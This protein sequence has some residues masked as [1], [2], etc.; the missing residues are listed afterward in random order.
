M[1]NL[2]QFSS[3]ALGDGIFNELNKT[4]TSNPCTSLTTFSFPNINY[5]EGGTEVVGIG[6]LILIV[7]HG[8]WQSEAQKEAI[9]RHVAK[10]FRSTANS[11]NCADVTYSQAGGGGERWRSFVSRGEDIFPIGSY[12]CIFHYQPVTI[13]ALLTLYKHVSITQSICVISLA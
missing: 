4:Y 6:T 2:Y 10:T 7:I 3:N 8:Y 11:T 9:L 1:G 12:L 5:S 13:E